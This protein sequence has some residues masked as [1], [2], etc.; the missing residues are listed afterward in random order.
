MQFHPDGSARRRVP[1][2]SERLFSPVLVPS[3]SL[4]AAGKRR[5]YALP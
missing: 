4:A 3:A 1:F 2:A 5:A